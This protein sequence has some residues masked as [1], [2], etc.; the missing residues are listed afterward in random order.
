MGKEPRPPR[1]SGPTVQASSGREAP[2]GG[3]KAGEG[4][5]IG[6][7]TDQYGR[8]CYGNECFTMALDEAR[9][10]VV[11]NIKPDASCDTQ[12]VIE[13]LRKML[14]VGARTVYEVESEVR[15]KKS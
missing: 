10:E 6:T 15:E 2:P 7:W 3:G 9:R 5:S 14:G 12:P 13:G 1:R 4:S 11:V 8:L